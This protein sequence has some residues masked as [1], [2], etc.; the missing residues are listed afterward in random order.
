MQPLLPMNAHLPSIGRCRT[1]NKYRDQFVMDGENLGS[2]TYVADMGVLFSLATPNKTKFKWTMTRSMK[3]NNVMGYSPYDIKHW[4]CN[5]N[6]EK[7]KVKDATGKV[8]HFNQA[9]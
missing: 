4:T 1:T 7:F 2:F 9:A 3:A 6:F 8:N 5:K